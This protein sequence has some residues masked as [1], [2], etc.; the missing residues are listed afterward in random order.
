MSPERPIGL[1]DER[2]HHLGHVLAELLAWVTT[3]GG[4]P[5]HWLDVKRALWM[6]RII[7]TGVEHAITPGSVA[8]HNGT[9]AL[10]DLSKMY[11]GMAVYAPEGWDYET[12]W[13]F[14]LAAAPYRTL[15]A[16]RDALDWLAVEL[17]L[18]HDPRYSET[19]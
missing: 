12:H 8:D 17:L 16:R 6:A 10:V 11:F 7:V 18:N 4:K 14:T 19:S 13:G 5:H 2:L 15:L 1:T 3:H 9:I